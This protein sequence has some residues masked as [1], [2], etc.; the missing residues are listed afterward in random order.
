MSGRLYVYPC[1]LVLRNQML[2]SMYT[3]EAVAASTAYK[4]KLKAL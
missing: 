3:R 4:M 2:Q 1:L